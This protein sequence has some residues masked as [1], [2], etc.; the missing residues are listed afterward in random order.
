MFRKSISTN[1]FAEE[2]VFLTEESAEKMIE[3]RIAQFITRY[4]MEP[5]A[6]VIHTAEPFAARIGKHYRLEAIYESGCPRGQVFPILWEA[7]RIACE[8]EFV[9]RFQDAEQ[10]LEGA[11]T[12]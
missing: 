8:R 6:L 7:Y 2:S 5:N 4:D 10:I 9:K 3:D 12:R 1:I 11:I